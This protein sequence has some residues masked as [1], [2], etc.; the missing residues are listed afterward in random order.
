MPSQTSPRNSDWT[1]LSLL[2]WSTACFEDQRIDSPRASAEI[3]LAHVLK[4]RRI[5]LYLRSDQQVAAAELRAFKALVRRRLAREPVAYITGVKEFWS[6]EFLVTKDVLIPRPETETL[7]EEALIRL[8]AERSA[9]TKRVLELGT[10][11]G[12]IILSLASQQPRHVY[13]ASDICDRAIQV[14]KLNARRHGLDGRV[15]FLCTNW[16]AG[17]SPEKSR[18]DLIVSN[19]PYI[20]T[21][22]IQRL[23]PEIYAYEPLQALDGGGDGLDCI[24][25]I[26]GTAWHFLSAGGVLMLEI[27]YDQGAGLRRIVDQSDWHDRFELKKDLGD[28]DR[29][30]W[31]RRKKSIAEH[32]IF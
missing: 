32:K 8:S 20:P 10:G 28:C 16:F 14:A 25:Q 29:V 6:M 13:L 23:Q 21:E 22:E 30:F 19:P 5:D 27:G 7:V 26:M 1:I 31:V 3:L 11:C 17:L 9:S 4:A 12:A 2:H 24:R 15:C 18:F